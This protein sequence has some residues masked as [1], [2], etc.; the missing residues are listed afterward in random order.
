MAFTSIDAHEDQDVAVVRVVGRH[1]D[2]VDL[3]QRHFHVVLHHLPMWVIPTSGF[4]IADA[5]VF[6]RLSP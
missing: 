4:H 2:V 1:H 5:G 6:S 3:H